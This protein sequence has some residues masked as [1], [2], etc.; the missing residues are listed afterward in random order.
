MSAVNSSTLANKKPKLE[1]DLTKSGTSI[2]GTSAGNTGLSGLTN[3]DVLR[4]TIVVT[5]TEALNL[6]FLKFSQYATQNSEI[7]IREDANVLA[8]ATGGNPGTRNIN[9]VLE[10][11][12]VETHTYSCYATYEGVLYQYGNASGGTVFVGVTANMDDTH[13]TKNTK[14][15]GG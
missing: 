5:P 7:E 9:I 15:I 1:G 13:S 3:T 14:I 12:T 11:V 8:S 6:V 10:D 4:G 2:V